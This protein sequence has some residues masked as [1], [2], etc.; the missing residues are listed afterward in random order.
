M[1]R[2]KLCS[3]SPTLTVSTSEH[4]ISATTSA[5]RD[6]RR[7]PPVARSRGRNAEERSRREKFNAG[8]QPKSSV[9][10]MVI[11]RVTNSAGA[12]KCTASSRGNGRFGIVV[13]TRTRLHANDRPAAHPMALSNIASITSCRPIC[14]KLAP[15]L[16]RRAI[17]P[18][19]FT[20]RASNNAATLMHATIRISA[21][22]ACG[23][24][25]ARLLQGGAW[26]GGRPNVRL[27]NSGTISQSN[28]I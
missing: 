12:F 26:S 25:L 13:N 21:A 28:A 5:D 24:A 16:K 7:R 1:T 17:S 15:R 4:A 11:T 9:V 23:F 8:I 6:D 2:Q 20:A 14:T 22:A 27:G 18:W 3:S 10:A 19:R